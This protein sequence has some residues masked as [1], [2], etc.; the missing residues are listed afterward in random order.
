MKR[1]QFCV[2]FSL[3]AWAT[4][5]R[6]SESIADDVVI[7]DFESASYD[8]WALTGDA[9]GKGPAAGT[10]PGQMDVSGFRGQ[11]LVNTFHGGDAS[12][13]TATSR[14]FT[15]TKP[16]LAFLIGG[17][18]DASAVGIE[19]IVDGQPVRRA[20]GADSE[21]LQW[22]SWE[23]REFAE[24]EATLRIY[25]RAR[26]GW[27][28]VNVDQITL[29]DQP[30]E[31]FDLQ[32]KLQRYRT[33]DDYYDE[34]F[35]PQVH[36][37]P[38]I[39]WMNDPNGLVYH[40][41]E[42]H[43]FYQY[44]PAGITWGHMS[45][46]HAVSRDMVHWEHLPVAIPEVDGVMAFSGCCVVDHHNTSGLGPD[47]APPMVAIY[48]G[49]GHGKQVQNLAYSNDNGRSWTR[50]AGN[51]VLD[52][53]QSDFR[54]PK[55]FWHQPTERW[56][57]VVALATERVIVFYQSPDLKHWEELS[58]FGP[59]GVEGKLNWE[60][61]DLFPLEV[62]NEPGRQLW[63]LEADMGSGSIAGGSGGEYF[64]GD[65]DGQKFTPIQSARWVDFG[66]D[67][68]AP[69]SWSNIPPSD[70]RRLWIGWFNNWETCL[71]PTSPW[72]S[73]M[74]VPR[75]L[76]LHQVPGEGGQDVYT[77]VQRPIQEL[78]SLRSGRR[79]LDTSAA[80]WPPVAVTAPG[81]LSDMS[82]VLKTALIPGTERSCG[83]RLR[84]GADEFTEVGYDR[85]GRVV[86][87]D[88]RRS[89][90]VDFHETFA[91][92]HEAPVRT[93]DGR[94]T[95]E[96]IV[97]RST[98]EVFINDGEAVI[99]DRIFPSSQQPVIEVFAGGETARLTDTTLF[100]LRSIWPDAPTATAS[101]AEG[102]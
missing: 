42:Y 23:V 68:Y 93:I 46:G 44:N 90:T 71:V 13:G 57:M 96:M 37:S 83:I 73:C 86:Y 15:L 72:R 4:F 97:D 54:D 45:W 60:C 89:G 29:V 92:R 22:Q 70:G 7:E 34:P 1:L 87:V 51:P 33:G 74:S 25:D 39:H 91:G 82:F 43:L 9:F 28:H 19:L 63:V 11:R 26:G 17:G 18:A 99:S 94:V 102:E 41:G 81:E 55:V 52:I 62:E 84:T 27:G 58:R 47:D 10:L 59:A 95:L 21:S 24:R 98:I 2:L 3:A 85:Q 49:H 50:Y 36:F 30:P 78:R 80:S 69:V 40:N 5:G 48:T 20:S 100:P 6:P 88:R 32:Y 67:F 66:R 14:P 75:T 56:V 53:G 64:V 38:E 61:P 77:L 31:R 101:G 65:F 79:D 16:Y 12:V 35:R 8:G 76:T